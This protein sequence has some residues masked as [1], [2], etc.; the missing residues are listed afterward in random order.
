MMEMTSLLLKILL[1]YALLF[2]LWRQV[3]MVRAGLKK[4]A[5]INGIFCK[6]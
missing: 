2:M 1:G 5:A 4:D 6:N 3:L